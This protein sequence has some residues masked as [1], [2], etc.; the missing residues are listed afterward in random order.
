MY[1]PQVETNREALKR[2][3]TMLVAMAEM[4]FGRPLSSVL[5]EAAAAPKTSRTGRSRPSTA[6]TLPRHLYRAI[7]RLLRPAESAARR[8]IVAA[9]RG[10]VVTLPPFR[11]RKPKP[12]DPA[13]MLRRLGLAVTLSRGDFARAETARKAAALRAARPRAINLPLL[14]ALE[15]PFRVRRKYVPAHAVPRISVP[16]FSERSPPPSPDDPIGAARLMLRLEALGRA[17]DDLPGQAGRFARWKARNDAARVRVKEGTEPWR[18]RHVL[19]RGL[20]YPPSLTFQ[21][22]T[23]GSP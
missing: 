3:L 7:L 10:I 6:F 1:I 5:Q 22:E 17:L 9:A 20:S 2:I 16:G 23:G 19:M 14:D 15:N 12:I 18:P 13:P 11:P 8:L 21:G 4:A